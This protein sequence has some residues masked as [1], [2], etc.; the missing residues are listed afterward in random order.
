MYYLFLSYLLWLF[1]LK[2]N[3]KTRYC[4]I[5]RYHKCFVRNMW[6]P[7][8]GHNSLTGKKKNLWKTFSQITTTTNIMIQWKRN[9]PWP[10][11]IKQAL[12]STCVQCTIAQTVHMEFEHNL[13]SIIK[14]LKSSSYVSSIPFSITLNRHIAVIPHSY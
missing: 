2:R 13:S 1:Q 14:D 6:L 10:C 12:L 8:K 4:Q 7:L 11:L 9:K 5:Y 3:L